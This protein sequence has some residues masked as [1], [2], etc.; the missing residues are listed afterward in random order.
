MK[1]R[2]TKQSWIEEK[3]E[4]QCRS[5]NDVTNMMRFS[6][7]QCVLQKAGMARLINPN[8]LQSLGVASLKQGF[9]QARQTLFVWFKK[10]C[11][12]RLSAA[13]CLLPTLIGAW[14]QTCP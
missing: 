10:V 2:W 8:L 13:C 1:G 14:Q 9:L 5:V 6:A 11:C 12:W 4:L 3:V 7:S